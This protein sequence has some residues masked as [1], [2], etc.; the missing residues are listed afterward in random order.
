MKP[1]LITSMVLLAT[2][3]AFGQMQESKPTTQSATSVN[4]DREFEKYCLQNATRLITA[5]EGKAAN[6][7]I[8][9]EVSAP[10]VKQPTYRDYGVTLK[11]NETQYFKISG[12]DQLLA[13]TSLYRL[14]AAYNAEQH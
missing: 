1:I 2:A 6:L 12:S 3:S 14:R 11:E 9:G 13:V 10:S 4:S 7:K 5:P 8:A